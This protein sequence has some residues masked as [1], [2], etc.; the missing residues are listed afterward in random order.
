MDEVAPARPERLIV[1]AQLL[2]D[3]TPEFFETKGPGV[4]DRATAAFLRRLQDC[5]TRLFHA[6]YSEKSACGSTAL[7]FDFYFPEERAAV[8]FAFGLHNPNS[9]FERDVFKCLLASED[10]CPVHKLFLVGKPG[11][12]Q[13]LGAPAPQAIIGFV[14]KRF[15]LEFEI[16]ELQRQGAGAAAA[17][18]TPPPAHAA[19]HSF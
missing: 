3:S 1:A 19:N 10:G 8:E 6:D 16:V 15:G 2:A 11:A 7:R 9:E 18:K 5:A 13:R 4:G 17:R 14:R 12:L